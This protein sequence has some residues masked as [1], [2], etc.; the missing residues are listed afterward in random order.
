MAYDPFYTITLSTAVVLLIL[1]LAYFG[2]EIAYSANGVVFP[3]VALPCPDYWTV[4]TDGSC[5]AEMTN[6]GTFATGTKIEPN[7]L[8][9]TCN[10]Q[11]WANKNSVWWDGVSN[12][13][14]CKE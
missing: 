8:G 6:L 7:K 12:Y 2:V 4:N 14:Q 13:N 5:T 11:T 10:Q 3:P 1:I 9:T